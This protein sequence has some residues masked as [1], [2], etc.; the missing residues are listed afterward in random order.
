METDYAYL[1]K[2]QHLDRVTYGDVCWDSGI[3]GIAGLMEKSR[4]YNQFYNTARIILAK[5]IEALDK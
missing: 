4:I 3:Y 2:L 1:K 5:G